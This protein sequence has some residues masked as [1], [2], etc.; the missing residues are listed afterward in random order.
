MRREDI[1][2][3]FASA[4][5]EQIKALLDINSADIGNALNKQKGALDT[6]MAD[7]AAANIRVKELEKA[8]GDAEALRKKVEEYET[9][10]KKRREEEAAAAELAELTERFDAVSGEREFLHEMVRKGVMTDFGAA[11]KDKAYRGKSDAEIFN[12]LTKDKDY[13]RIQNPPGNMQPVNANIGQTD[14]DK[15]NDNEY[16]AKVFAKK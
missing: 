11:L 13:F 1:L 16:Y 14:L 12:A 5:D 9:A 3:H 6:A 7:L 2:K 10:D 4:T 15:L 8:G